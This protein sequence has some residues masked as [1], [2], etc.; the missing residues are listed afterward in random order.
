MTR[1][2]KYP[3]MGRARQSH[4][5]RLEGMR[6]NAAAGEFRAEPGVGHPALSGS[7]HLSSPATGTTAG[8]SWRSLAGSSHSQEPRDKPCRSRAARRMPAMLWTAF[9]MQ[10]N[11]FLMVQHPPTL[12]ASQTQALSG[13]KR[14][15]FGSFEDCSL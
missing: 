8:G 12:T 11:A 1:L 7:L 9:G 13:Q 5:R 3:L 15:A 14:V 6:G 10:Q 2:V 4:W